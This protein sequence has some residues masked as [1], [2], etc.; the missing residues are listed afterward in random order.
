MNNPAVVNGST[1]DWRKILGGVVLGVLWMCC[2]LFINS[3]LI[4]DWTGQPNGYTTN[5]KFFVAI[6]GLLIIVFYHIF[7]RSNAETNKL[8]LTAIFTLAWLS[9]ILF[10]PFR[11]TG[12][13]EGYRGATAFF[14]LVGGLAVSVFWVR[15][16][17]DEIL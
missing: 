13:S 17:A 4:I 9:L 1:M 11:D 15:F 12:V 8:S 2:F 5:F 10:Y 3:T 14:T 6:V 7:Y 16:F